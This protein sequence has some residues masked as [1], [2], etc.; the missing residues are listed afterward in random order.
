MASVK[1]MLEKNDPNF[2][3]AKRRQ[4]NVYSDPSIIEAGA[5]ISSRPACRRNDPAAFGPSRAERAG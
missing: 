1:L 5:L 2:A 3:A 4:V